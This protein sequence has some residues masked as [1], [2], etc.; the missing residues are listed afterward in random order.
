MR[1]SAEPLAAFEPCRSARTG[2][3]FG[4]FASRSG[5]LPIQL[6]RF[7]RCNQELLGFVFKIFASVSSQERPSG[8][9]HKVS[10]LPESLARNVTHLL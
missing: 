4:R 8:R 7:N 10:R 1:G 2:C 9:L 5:W 6:N 3:A